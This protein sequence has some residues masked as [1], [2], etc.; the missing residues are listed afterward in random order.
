MA[1][2][3]RDHFAANIGCR[4]LV[5]LLALDGRFL[6]LVSA[7]LPDLL[8]AKVHVL[9]GAVA[10]DF[11]SARAPLPLEHWHGDAVVAHVLCAAAGFQEALVEVEPGPAL[12]VMLLAAAQ[13]DG[14][15]ANRLDFAAAVDRTLGHFDWGAMRPDALVHVEVAQWMFWA[16]LLLRLALCPA[17][18]WVD[19]FTLL[20]QALLLL[21]FA[22]GVQPGHQLARAVA[23][24]GLL[25]LDPQERV[26]PGK[27]RVGDAIDH[28]RQQE[29]R[30]T[31]C[32][33]HL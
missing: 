4:A 1:G 29:H 13:A 14:R 2:L 24:D 28:T 12:L 8:M 3:S 18:L 17:Q 9:L 11:D 27:Q 31:N 22:V 6:A 32:S 7:V 15:G 23:E 10:L 21:I 30:Q 33:S 20:V 26:K 25:Q 16:V 5:R 19:L